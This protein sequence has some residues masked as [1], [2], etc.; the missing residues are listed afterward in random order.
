MPERILLDGRRVTYAQERLLKLLEANS[1]RQWCLENGVTHSTAWKIA[2]GGSS[3]LY[4]TVCSM[5]DIIP[6]VEWIFYTDEVLPYP[7]RLL[8]K[9]NPSEISAFV[10]MHRK[11]YRQ[12]AGRY[13][14]PELTAYNM[15]VAYR[16]KPT[17][18]FIRDC[19]AETDPCNFFTGELIRGFSGGSHALPERGD[20][21]AVGGE[22]ILVLSRKEAAEKGYVLGCPVF[23]EAT[24]PDEDAVRLPGEVISGYVRPLTLR[25]FFI[26]SGGGTEPPAIRYLGKVPDL[27]F[28]EAVLRKIRPLL[29]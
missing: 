18:A 12:I 3:P 25:S 20:I 21:L 9:W 14:L 28:P 27:S 26:G 16:T 11:D 10:R 29:N 13:G 4:S 8:P 17:L 22:Y 24:G 1:L 19:C 15:F 2:T 7:P 23:P 6:A 5:V